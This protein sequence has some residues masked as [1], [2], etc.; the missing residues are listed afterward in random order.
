MTKPLNIDSDMLDGALTKLRSGA[1]APRPE[2]ANP[3]VMLLLAYRH[4]HWFCCIR[5]GVDVRCDICA[6]VDALEGK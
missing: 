1:K 5:Q 4:T 2:P 3:A 6:K